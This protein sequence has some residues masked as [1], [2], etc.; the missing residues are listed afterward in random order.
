MDAELTLRFADTSLDPYVRFF[1]PR[2]SPFTTAVA[3][4]TIRVVGELADVDHLVV[5]A[6]VE[7]LDLKLFDYRLRN[8][9]PI[10]LAL[11]QHVA[12]GR[13]AP[14]RRRGHRARAR[15]ADRLRPQRAR[16]RRRRATPTSASCRGST[17]TSAAAAPRRSR[18][19]SAVRSTSRCSPA[20]PTSRTAASAAVAAALARGDQR[21][22]LVRRRRR[23]RRRRGGAAG[24]RRRAV[25]RPDRH[26]RLHPGRPE[27]DRDRRA[28]AD[29]LSRKGSARPSTRIWRCGARWPRRC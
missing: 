11:D 27:P 24:R 13:P 2:L 17:A 8:E 19:R 20:A 25:R 10:E 22:A 14:A 5:E 29:P 23:P 21:P 3:G 15:R 28:D 18:R 4:G 9:G 26:Q 16:G 6:H 1:E 7:S 12:R